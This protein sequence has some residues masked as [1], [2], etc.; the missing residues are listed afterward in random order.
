MQ[1]TQRWEELIQLSVR[2]PTMSDNKRTKP[3]RDMV[4]RAADDFATAGP[5][6]IGAQPVAP[7][8]GNVETIDAI[9]VD[10][11]AFPGN[12]FPPP[13]LPT[14][15]F[16]AD[17][18]AFPGNPLPTAFFAVKSTPPPPPPPLPPAPP[19][20]PIYGAACPTPFL[21]VPPSPVP[22]FQLQVGQ[23]QVPQFHPVYSS[24]DPR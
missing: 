7:A 8:A 4:R 1:G 5:S 20:P 21:V 6:G 19:P 17:Q 13:T 23:E 2:V 16:V 15:P 3:T 24:E 18:P 11:P 9:V 14:G 12:P 10:Q 22:Q